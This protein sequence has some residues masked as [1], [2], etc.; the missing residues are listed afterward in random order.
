MAYCIKCGG[1]VEDTDKKCPF[2][3]ADIPVV[4]SQQQSQTQSQAQ[5][6]KYTYGQNYGQN[7]SDQNYNGQSSYNPYYPETAREGYFNEAE[8]KKNKVMGVLCYL[9]IL[10]FIPILAGDKD[11]EYLK[12]HKNQGL[13]LFIINVIADLLEKSWI[14]IGF[15]GNLTGAVISVGCDIISFVLAILWILGIVYACKGT[16]NELPG[17]GKI[18]IFK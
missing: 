9:G 10:V 18:K 6:S 12:L 13:V 1:R 8:V 5:T 16:K 17:I 15:L 7:H 2:C 3:G 4:G 14:R 11:S